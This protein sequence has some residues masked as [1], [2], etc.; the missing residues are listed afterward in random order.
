MNR[1]GFI[2]VA[3]LAALGP[4]LPASAD[5]NAP[6][7]TV[8]QQD[9]NGC[10]ASTPDVVRPLAQRSQSAGIQ[11]VDCRQDATRAAVG[12]CE[13]VRRDRGAVLRLVRVASSVI[14]SALSPAYVIAKACKRRA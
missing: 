4:L 13:L 6:R 8:Q 5:A 14:R 12:D 10:L 1:T 3:A 7:S 11:R 9:Q 2:L